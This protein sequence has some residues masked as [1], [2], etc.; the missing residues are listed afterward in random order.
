MLKYFYIT[1][2]CQSFECIIGDLSFYMICVKK[3]LYSCWLVFIL[4]LIS[5]EN[6]V[7]PHASTRMIVFTTGIT[8]LLD[9]LCTYRLNFEPTFQESYHAK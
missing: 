6:D 1:N 5:S 7:K 2:V 3:N 9:I 4:Q 8:F